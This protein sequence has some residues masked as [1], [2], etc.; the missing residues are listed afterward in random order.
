MPD[1]FVFGS[2]VVGPHVRD[3]H[4]AWLSEPKRNGES[5][6]DSSMRRFRPS[7]QELAG[8]CAAWEKLF[9]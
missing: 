4:Q 7:E 3:A 8:A 6:K 9:S 5:R 1:F 2:D